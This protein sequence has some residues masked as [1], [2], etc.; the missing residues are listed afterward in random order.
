MAG[1]G[2]AQKITTTLVSA[3]LGLSMS[4]PVTDDIRDQQWHLDFLDIERAHEISTG[5]GVIVGIIDSG[6]DGGHPD[7]AGQLLPGADFSVE[8]LPDALVDR[9]GHGTAMAGLIAADGRAIGVAP[10]AT[11]LPVRGSTFAT[12]A[13]VLDE[14]IDWAVDNGASVLCLAFGYTRSDAR[15]EAA[16][17]RAI[18]RDVVVVAAVGNTPDAPIQ[19]PAAYPG[20]VAAAGVDRQGDHAAVSVVSASTVLAAPSVDVMSTESRSVTP[21]GYGARTGTSD[22]TAIIAGVAALVRSRFPDLPAAEVIHR[23]TYTADDRG[24]PG[25]DDEYGYGIVN[26]VAALTADVPLLEPSTPPSSTQAGG[27]PGDAS[28]R[29]LIVGVVT[30]VGVVVLIIVGLVL[31]LRRRT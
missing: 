29:A 2:W 5:G 26:P 24:A 19:Y 16:V 9:D 15:L 23:M 7:L 4:Q 27:P 10:D 17:E 6:V 28:P 8:G 31:G 11:V 25:R 14:A 3:V 30:G 1:P 22:A 12:T 21:A 20:V 18:S 13:L